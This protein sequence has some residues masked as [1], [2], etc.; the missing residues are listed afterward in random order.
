MGTYNNQSGNVLFL[1]LIAVALFAALS[2]AVTQSTRGGGDASEEKTGI[3]LAGLT[4]YGDLISTSILRSRIIN[5]LEDWELCFHS[6]NWGHNDYLA[7]TP[8]NV[9]GNSATNIFSNDGMGVPW[10]EPDETLLDTSRSADPTY[11]AYRYTAWR[12]KNIGDDSLDEIM[13]MVSYIKRDTCI[14]INDELGI[15]NTGG[16]PPVEAAQIS[17]STQSVYN[18][19]FGSSGSFCAGASLTA[20]NGNNGE[21]SGQHSGCFYSTNLWGVANGY[22][23]YKVLAPR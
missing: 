20:L 17:G 8:V 19:R 16:H 22:V 21:L 15:T 13:M 14:K 1:I 23:Y 3:Q 5:K 10:S 7:N 18:C 4:Q 11:G 6:N 12:V 9:C 2:Y